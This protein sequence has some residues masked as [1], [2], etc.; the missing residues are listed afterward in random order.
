MQTN[1]NPLKIV[2]KIKENIYGKNEENPFST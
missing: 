1:F 2:S